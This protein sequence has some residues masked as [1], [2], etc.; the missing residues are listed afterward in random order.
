MHWFKR[1]F[2]METV[3]KCIRRKVYVG[4]CAATIAKSARICIAH[5]INYILTQWLLTWWNLCS[6]SR[7]CSASLSLLNTA[8]E[9]CKHLRQKNSILDQCFW[10][11]L[12]PFEFILISLLMCT[13]SIN[14]HVLN[15]I[16]GLN[17]FFLNNRYI[18]LDRSQKFSENVWMTKM[19]FDSV[20]PK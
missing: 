2:Q 18:T 3:A 13:V 12:K 1:K 19:S 11:N 5:P 17:G 7:F 16:K 8:L 20:P 6:R 10:H 9:A 4:R 14:I 15:P